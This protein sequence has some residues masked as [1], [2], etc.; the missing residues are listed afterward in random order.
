M[1]VALTAGSD[2]EREGV[3]TRAAREGSEE[4]VGL[5]VEDSGSENTD[6]GDGD[7]EKDKENQEKEEVDEKEKEGKEEEAGEEE[8]EED[9]LSLERRLCGVFNDM[10][11]VDIPADTVARRLWQLPIH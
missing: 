5:M 3:V 10:A 2:D 1:V 11:L 7:D 6:D 4:N 8:E 9:V